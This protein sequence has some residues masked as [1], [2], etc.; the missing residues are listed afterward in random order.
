VTSKARRATF[1][2]T[3]H[4]VIVQSASNVP[5]IPSP[6]E[7]EFLFLKERE[8]T[9][10]SGLPAMS[11]MHLFGPYLA[12]GPRNVPHHVTGLVCASLG[13]FRIAWSRMDSPR[14]CPGTLCSHRDRIPQRSVERLVDRPWIASFAGASGVAVP[15]SRS[16]ILWQC[17]TGVQQT[18]G[19]PEAV[20]AN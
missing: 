6:P 12:L 17:T 19:R 3:F 11:A 8:P 18:E 14:R 16:V 4:Y 20:E 13:A 15:K 7:D 2:L 5:L 9:L 10:L 1:K